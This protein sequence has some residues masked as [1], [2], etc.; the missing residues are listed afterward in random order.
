VSNNNNNNNAAEEN[1]AEAPRAAAAATTEPPP[2]AEL[3]D[4]TNELTD[5]AQALGRVIEQQTRL[6][7][8]DDLRTID[9]ANR[10]G[11]PVA[12]GH[13]GVLIAGRCQERTARN[14]NEPEFVR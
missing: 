3:P 14:I 1:N 8:A 6:K 12:D 9:R 11:E 10:G 7:M 2:P 13:G 5:R 4:F